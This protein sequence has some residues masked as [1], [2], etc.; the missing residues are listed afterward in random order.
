MKPQ[1]QLI[2]L[3]ALTSVCTE[4]ETQHNAEPLAG[5]NNLLY[6]CAINNTI[7]AITNTIEQLFQRHNPPSSYE[8]DV[9]TNSH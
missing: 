8:L 9:R 4:I 1:N 3:E 2:L 6:T 5:Q 7:S